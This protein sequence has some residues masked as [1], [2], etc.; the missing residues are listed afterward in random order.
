[1]NANIQD[2]TVGIRFFE[3]APHIK[4]N[5]PED[6]LDIEQDRALATVAA[7]FTAP[8][9]CNDPGVWLADE[10]CLSLRLLALYA[11]GAQIRLTNEQFSHLDHVVGA[12]YSDRFA[13]AVKTTVGW[14]RREAYSRASDDGIRN[15][16][17]A[18]RTEG[19]VTVDL[20]TGR[21]YGDMTAGLP[22][23]FFA[24]TTDDDAG[25]RTIR[26]RL[27]TYAALFGAVRPEL[28]NRES[29]AIV[30]LALY[31]AG[32]R[33]GYTRQQFRSLEKRVRAYISSMKDDRFPEGNSRA[34]RYVL[35]RAQSRARGCGVI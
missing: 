17:R 31:A 21:A 20:E 14:A 32:A 28:S 7:L 30:S 19:L 11:A 27:L 23:S 5:Q 2:P 24:K 10:A 18:L 1:M 26:R 9:V 25:A 35:R 13:V 29:E 22:E 3:A 33:V 4:P 12:F 34:A 6:L 8:K 16:G 15:N